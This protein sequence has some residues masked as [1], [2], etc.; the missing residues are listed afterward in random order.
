MEY[1]SPNVMIVDTSFWDLYHKSISQ[2]LL[3][4]MLHP[5]HS[6]L[7][8][9]LQQGAKKQQLLQIMINR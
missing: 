7:L 1:N 4:E 9:R 8:R 3:Q 5:E 6:G 2:P